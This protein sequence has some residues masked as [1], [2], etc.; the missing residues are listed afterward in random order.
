[1]DMLEDTP[2]IK[3]WMTHSEIKKGVVLLSWNLKYSL[4]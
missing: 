3:D 1:M 4:E 2:I